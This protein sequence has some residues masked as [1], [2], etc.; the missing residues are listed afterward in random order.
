MKK[1]LFNLF[2]LLSIYPIFKS[3]CEN[4]NE[5]DC[6]NSNASGTYPDYCCYYKPLIPYNE[7]GECKTIPYFSYFKGLNREYI[8]GTLYNVT[9]NANRTTFALEECGDIHRKWEASLKNCKKH[10][11]P[12]DSCCYYSGKKN[13]NNNTDHGQQEFEKGCY[14]LGSKY[15]GSINWAGITLECNQNYLN[16]YVFYILLFLEFFCFKI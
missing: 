2:Y 16:Y 1:I 7:T 13:N 15:E 14:W 9:C 8:N 5:S 6:I 3:Q 12:L 10:S 4:K 11:T